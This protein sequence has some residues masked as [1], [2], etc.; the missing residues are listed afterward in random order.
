MRFLDDDIV[1]SQKYKHIFY[2]KDPS[3][4][5]IGYVRP[6]LTS[7]PMI[8]ELQSRWIAKVICKKVG[9]PELQSMETENTAD[10]LK[11]QKEFPCAYERLQ[12]II[13]PYSYCNMVADKINAN[14]NWI[15]LFFMDIQFFY[16]TIFGSWNHMIYRLNDENME[17]RQIAVDS[18]KNV[19]NEKMSTKVHDFIFIF[20]FGI[21]KE[22]LF[23]MLLII[24]IIYILYQVLVS[25]SVTQPSIRNI[26][27]SVFRLFKKSK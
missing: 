9:L 13:D 10:D 11:Q 26:Q 12:T 6:Y 5:F 17:K 8:T 21:V 22:W 24:T 14:V 19:Y 1:H 2:T 16:K 3:I 7:I 15:R 20:L 27:K 18:I 25:W 23:C 4:M